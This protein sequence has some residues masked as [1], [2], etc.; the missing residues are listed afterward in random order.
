MENEIEN[1]LQEINN[2]KILGQKDLLENIKRSLKIPEERH[3]S[4][5][6]SLDRKRLRELN[7]LETK[8]Q[9][10]LQG[11]EKTALL[12][13]Q[14][15]LREMRKEAEEVLQQNKRKGYGHVSAIKKMMLE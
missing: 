7:R 8:L 14:S 12:D 11:I 10:Q 1:K 3:K 15:F 6:P 9:Q 13:Q 5:P 2:K 4:I